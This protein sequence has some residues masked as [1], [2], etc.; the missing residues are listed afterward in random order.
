MKSTAWVGAPLI[1]QRTAMMIATMPVV[2]L[3]GL[4]LDGTTMNSVLSDT[5]ASFVTG[6]FS[7]NQSTTTGPS[8]SVST[9]G[10]AATTTA[11]GPFVMPGVTLGIF[12]TGLIITS[13]WTLL[14]SLA[15]GLGTMGRIHVRGE[16]R[17]RTKGSQAEDKPGRSG[18]PI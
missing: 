18:T 13:S 2:T 7:N 16:Y 12:P 17:K 3:S 6:V 11:A 8:P 10:A 5:E 14:F 4:A 15:V 9:A 1:L